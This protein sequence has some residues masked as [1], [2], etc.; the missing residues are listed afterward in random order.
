AR[1]NAIGI[2]PS[3][4]VFLFKQKTAYEFFTG[5]EFRR[6]LF[7]SI[8]ASASSA[9]AMYGVWKAP[10]T[11]SVITRVRA[12]GL[13]LNFSSRSS[14]PAAKIGRASRRDRVG[15]TAAADAF[16]NETRMDHQRVRSS[17][18]AG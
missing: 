5:L 9:G 15:K 17:N 4:A 18:A 3:M 7:R 10:A 12:G 8:A 2:A 6:V 14:A 1:A 11:C 13:A 16:K